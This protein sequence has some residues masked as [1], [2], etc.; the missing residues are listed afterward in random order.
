MLKLAL[1]DYDGLDP[2]ILAPNIYLNCNVSCNFVHT[3]STVYA[4]ASTIEEDA[5]EDNVINAFKLC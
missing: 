4:V 3:R 5:D 2:F 1:A